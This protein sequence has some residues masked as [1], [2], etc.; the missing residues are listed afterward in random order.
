MHYR[1]CLMALLIGAGTVL[2]ADDKPGAV[3][4]MKVDGSAVRKVAQVAN[5]H[6]HQAPRWSPNGKQIA[7][8]ANR[9]ENRSTSRRVFVVDAD[10]SG[11]REAARHAMPDWSPDGKQLAFQQFDAGPS[12]PQ[13]MVQNLDGQGL[14]KITAGRSPRWSPDGS[15]LA[16][17]E[18]RTLR[19]VDLVSGEEISMFGDEVDEL[20]RGFDWSPDG[21]RLAVVVR[22]QRG[23]PRELMIVSTEVDQPD[24][25]ARLRGGMGG[26]VSFSPDGEQLVFADA[27]KILI[28]RVNSTDPPQRV[29]GQRGV[30][31]DPDWSPDGEWIVFVSN[32]DSAGK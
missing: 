32:R 15:R 26:F 21:K 23:K 6:E 12:S 29:P 22:P 19:L 13:V 31:R 27:N 30:C 11:L 17:W 8:D 9:D 20:F 4:V 16:V 14:T 7:F 28:A 5:Y 18:N 3:Y 2:R 24:K 1:M 25:K 10:G